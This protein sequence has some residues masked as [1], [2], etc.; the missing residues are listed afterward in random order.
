LLVLVVLAVGL[1]SNYLQD[2]LVG[3]L[4]PTQKKRRAIYADGCG[5]VVN[6]TVTLNREQYVSK[7]KAEDYKVFQEKKILFHSIIDKSKNTS[8]LQTNDFR[9][10]IF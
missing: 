4:R 5:P 8:N 10:M 7:I 9:K 6:T 3:F 2:C 1:I